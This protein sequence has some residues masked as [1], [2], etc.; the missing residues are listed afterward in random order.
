[1]VVASSTLS[2]FAGCGVLEQ[3]L[4]ELQRDVAALKEK[5]SKQIAVLGQTAMASIER[6][7][8]RDLPLVS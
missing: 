4:G 8:Y 1:M 7:N 2:L 5:I 3:N 6:A